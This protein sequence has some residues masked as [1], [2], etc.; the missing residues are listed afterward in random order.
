MFFNSQRQ[1]PH[2]PIA[3]VIHGAENIAR[4]HA[5]GTIINRYVLRLLQPI[6]RVLHEIV[7]GRRPGGYQSGYFRLLR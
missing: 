4:L 7:N 6:L 2:E 3:G 5:S 1:H